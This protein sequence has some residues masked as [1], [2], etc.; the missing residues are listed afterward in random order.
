MG[1]MTAAA[2]LSRLGRRVLL[3]EQHLVPGGFT[4]TFRRPGYH[5]DVGVHIVG[6]MTTD[7]Y[8]GR[9]LHAL[10][11]GRLRWQSVGEVYDEFH[12]PEGF[13]IQFPSSIEAFR[14]VLGEAFPGERAAIDA[15]LTLVRQ[16]ARA[17]ASLMQ[18]RVM[19]RVLAPG[20]ARKAERGALPH[21][22]ATTAGVLAGLTDDPHL[23]SVLAAQ[24]GYYGSPPSRSSFAMHALM[25]AHFLRGAFY[26]V[27]GAASIARELLTT[28]AEAGGWTA[29]RRPVAEVIVRRGAAVGVCLEDGTEVPARAVVSAAGAGPTA[30]LLPGRALLPD[31]VRAVWGPA[32]VSL[33]LGFE[34]DVAGAGATTASQWF[35]ESW[36]MEVDRWPVAPGRVQRQAPVLFNSFP[37][38]KDPAHDPGP[39]L[40][41][42][43]EAI[44]FVP[45]E[46]FAPWAGTRW[47]RRGPGYDEFKATLTRSLLEQYAGHYPRLGPMIRHAELSTPLSTHHFARSHH[48]S[49]YGLAAEPWRFLGGSLLPRTPIRRLY[50]AGADVMTPGI[51]GAMG[52]GVLAVLAAEPVR[53][54]RFLRPIMQPQRR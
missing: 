45:W 36:D 43:G 51:A 21:L 15:Y 17:T 22:E 37:S 27:G 41:H 39:H 44:T 49:I 4:Q 34:G 28:V 46:S 18:A 53:A 40:R 31:P 9:L 54:L 8:P 50:L 12:F 23:R 14:E 52:G 38:L 19:P 26:P 35:Y 13:A 10:T 32:H 29:V 30:A 2:L 33:Y 3:L 25:V 42:T 20:A 24:W 6:E 5:W 47:Q 11:D 48:G 7:R 1:G 16:A